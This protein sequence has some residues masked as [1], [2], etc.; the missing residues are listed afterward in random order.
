MEIRVLKEEDIE[1]VQEFLFNVIEEDFGYQ[2]NPVWHADIVKMKEFYI[3]D[4]RSHFLVGWDE[5]GNI[6]GTIA[7]RKYNNNYPEL[8]HLYSGKP[9]SMICRHFV[10]KALRNKRV[11]TVLLKA[12]ES[13]ARESGVSILYLHTQ[14]TVPGSLEYWKAKGYIIT[15]EMKDELRTVHLDKHL[16]AN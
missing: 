9:T 8:N 3:Q 4:P 16:L 11:G 6:V 5:N 7:I 10:A 14:T 2:Y 15:L 1:D 13:Y 12:M